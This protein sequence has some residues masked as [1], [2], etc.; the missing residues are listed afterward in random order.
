MLPLIFIKPKAAG[1]KPIIG[2]EMY[3]APAPVLIK[4]TKEDRSSSSNRFSQEW[5]RYKNYLN[6]PLASIEGFYSRPRIDLELL[7]QYHEGLV[8]LSGCLKG[9][10]CFCKDQYEQARQRAEH[11]S[12]LAMI[13]IWKLWTLPQ[14]AAVNTGLIR[15]SKDLGIKLVATN[16]VH[17]VKKML[18]LRMSCSACKHS[19]SIPG[20]L[21]TNSLFKIASGNVGSLLIILSQ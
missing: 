14:L 21:D 7:R 12:Y 1:I 9:I 6:W 4:E 20:K 2:C 17:Y 13:F 10:A 8:V 15:L 3:Q 16:D 19:F 11:V 5:S 18:M